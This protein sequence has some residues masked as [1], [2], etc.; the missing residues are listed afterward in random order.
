MGKMMRLAVA[1]ATGLA[2]LW[3]LFYTFKLF[4]WGDSL[5][6][7]QFPHLAT[8]FVAAAWVVIALVWFVENGGDDE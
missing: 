1:W 6:W 5:S 7:W 8:M 3:A 2:A 4:P